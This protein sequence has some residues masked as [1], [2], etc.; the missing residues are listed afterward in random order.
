M[1][2]ESVAF[3]GYWI[4]PDDLQARSFLT[5]G[6]ATR[7]YKRRGESRSP[8]SYVLIDPNPEIYGRFSSIVGGPARYRQAYLSKEH[9]PLLFPT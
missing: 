4:P 5:I 8:D 2:G 6:W 1:D 3:L 7:V 9:L